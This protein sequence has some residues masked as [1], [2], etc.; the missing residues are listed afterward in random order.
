MHC[1]MSASIPDLCSLDANSIPPFETAPKFSRHCQ[2]SLG[3]KLPL[4]EHHG[5]RRIFP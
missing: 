2:M 4:V 1:R 3:D 5:H